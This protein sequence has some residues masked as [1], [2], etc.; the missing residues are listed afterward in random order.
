M[1][2]LER[3]RGVTHARRCRAA[4][5][6]ACIGACISLG[7]CGSSS[8]NAASGVTGGA[9]GLHITVGALLPLTGDLSAYGGALQ[10]AARLAVEQ[11]NAA[12]GADHIRNV[13]VSLA[14]ADTQT[15]PAEAVTAARQLIS[16]GASC[17][18]GP[19][20]SAETI[21]VGQ[22]V[23]A[24][25]HVPVISESATSA[26][27]TSLH[28]AFDGYVFRTA[29]S[30]NLQGPEIAKLVAERLGG[31]TGKT[32]SLA[33][34]NDSY[35][36]GLTNQIR[37]AWA[38]LGGRVQ[39]PLLYDP[40][41]TNFDAEAAQIVAGHPNAY[42]IIDFPQTYAAVGAALLRTGKFDQSRL[43]ISDGLALDPIPKSIPVQAL[44][45]AEG[46]R[47]STTLS[48]AASAAYNKLY[49]QSPGTQSRANFDPENFDATILCAL[50]AL[51]AHSTDGQQIRDKLQSISDPPGPQAT[52]LQLPQAVRDLRAGQKINYQGVSGPINWDAQG[53]VTSTTF[54]V[55]RYG[56][57]KLKVVGQLQAKQ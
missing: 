27:I 11:V 10:K 39:G 19:A 36:Q 55:Y 44:D 29:A 45:G 3:T 56:S 34:R 30:D 24:T 15:Q 37:S 2:R 8:G 32:I 31:A 13:T 48:G 33:G 40:T 51:A 17:L 5:I 28:G 7:A 4:G 42:V 50:G 53:D 49:S 25:Q 57:G 35:G 38:G 26:Q 52:Y 18:V 21:A 9:K 41:A 22:S 46:T 43:F 16:N 12:L 47:P 23:A 14:T 6:L 54:D 20:S 1:S